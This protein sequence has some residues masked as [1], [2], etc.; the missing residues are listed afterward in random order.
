MT[1]RIK[2]VGALLALCLFS[3]TAVAQAPLTSTLAD[4]TCVKLNGYMKAN[5]PVPPAVSVPAF[6]PTD[7]GAYIKAVNLRSGVAEVYGGSG[8]D[9]VFGSNQLAGQQYGSACNEWEQHGKANGATPPAWPAFQI[10]SLKDFDSWWAMY[11]LRFNP[12]SPFFGDDEYTGVIARKQFFKQPAPSLPAVVI[13]QAA[14]KASLPDTGNPV[15]ARIPGSP[16][17]AL[18]V[19]GYSPGDSDPSGKYMLI[20]PSPMNSDPSRF[21]WVR[22]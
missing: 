11:N 20:N 16:F 19:S 13:A 4:L 12:T 22:Q 15:G 21:V 9:A 5:M 18:A 3:F 6:N 1:K 7:S 17:F 8:P 14:V 10:V 2:F